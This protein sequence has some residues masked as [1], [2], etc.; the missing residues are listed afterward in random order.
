MLELF[1]KTTNSKKVPI[2][3]NMNF[4]PEGGCGNCGKINNGLHFFSA[5]PERLHLF[6]CHKCL[7]RY[8]W[9]RRNDLC[10]KLRRKGQSLD[11]VRRPKQKASLRPAQDDEAGPGDLQSA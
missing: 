9:N 4:G 5:K 1:V 8:M 7:G 3:G 2:T 10:H 6:I 11:H